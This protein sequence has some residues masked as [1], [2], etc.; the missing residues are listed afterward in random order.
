[1]L[2]FVHNE[3]ITS[4]SD[5]LRRVLCC[6]Q[7]LRDGGS[8]RGAI[9][10]GRGEGEGSPRGKRGKGKMWARTSMEA[11]VERKRQAGKPGLGLANWLTAVGSEHHRLPVGVWYPALGSSG[12]AAGGLQCERWRLG[13]GLGGLFTHERHLLSL[14]TSWPCGTISLQG[15]QSPRCP[16]TRNI[17][18]AHSFRQ[19]FLSHPV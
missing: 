3:A 11:S 9:A 14:A 10:G 19:L 12:W 7:F 5:C 18:S 16:R 15:Q 17:Q 6:P 1:M 4:G 2:L 13:K 8:H